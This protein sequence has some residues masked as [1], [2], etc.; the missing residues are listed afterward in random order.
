MKLPLAIFY[1][2]LSGYALGETP[3]RAFKSADGSREFIGELV[4]YKSGSEKAT[5]RLKSTQEVTS[6][7]LTKL[8]EADQEYVKTTGP[9][10]TP[11]VSLD[12][13]FSKV[14]E[15][16]Q[17][18]RT[19]KTRVKKYDGGY[20]IELRNYST[21][22]IDDVDVNYLVIYRKDATSGNGERLVHSGSESFE[23]LVPKVSREIMAMGVELENYFKE[24]TATLSTSSGCSTC[25]SSS[26]GTATRAEKSRDLLLGCI[27]QLKVGGKV[28]LTEA[29]SPDILRQY[30]DSF[31]GSE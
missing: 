17:S 13:R 15:L 27:V 11:K 20:K 10:L 26:S 6:I 3:W 14:M 31:S 2:V 19:E 16:S 7:E 24:G 21:E 30:S 12:L 28:V 22:W 18:E 25:P 23:Y 5:V 29:S 9:E 8:S 4:A 1:S